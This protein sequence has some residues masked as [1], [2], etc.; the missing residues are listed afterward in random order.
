MTAPAT[1]SAIAALITPLFGRTVL[2][3]DKAGAESRYTIAR[4]SDKI[5]TLKDGSKGEYVVLTKDGETGV[6]L[7]IHPNTAKK[8]AAKGEG[9][10]LKLVP[11]AELSEAEYQLAANKLAAEGVTVVEPEGGVPIGSEVVVAT[12]GAAAEATEQTAPVDEAPAPAAAKVSKKSQTVAIFKE[13]TAAGKPRKEIIAKMKAD[14]G[15]SDACCNTYYQ[16][17]KSGAWA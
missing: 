8:L 4:L 17:C 7:N 14:L 3:F 9:D 12:E 10:N 13:L 11:T 6:V 2:S 16:N 1:V 5:G 15:I